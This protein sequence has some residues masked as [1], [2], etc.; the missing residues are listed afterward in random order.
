[1]LIFVFLLELNFKITRR[2]RINVSN[3]HQTCFYGSLTNEASPRRLVTNQEDCFKTLEVNF[4]ILTSLPVSLSSHQLILDVFH[5]HI[6]FRANLQKIDPRTTF[7]ATPSNA[8]ETKA[9]FSSKIIFE[10]KPIQFRCLSFKSEM[11]ILLIVFQLFS[12]FC[13]C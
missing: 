8:D 3:G 5:Y 6:F 4:L 11:K 9:N 2:L 12:N 1:M 7:E 10:Q 13:V